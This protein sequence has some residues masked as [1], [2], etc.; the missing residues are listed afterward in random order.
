MA[1]AKAAQPVI[2]S[3]PS[4]YNFGSTTN[5]LFS[6]SKRFA[7]MKPGPAV[8]ELSHSPN[9]QDSPAS[10][11]DGRPMSPVRDFAIAADVHADGA[12]VC[13]SLLLFFLYLNF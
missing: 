10:S 8:S 5:S 13:Y 4:S 2:N 12:Q 1:F 6:H 11:L 7:E 3:L 9:S